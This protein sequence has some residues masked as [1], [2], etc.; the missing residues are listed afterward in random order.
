M[1]TKNRFE[2]RLDNETAK[3]FDEKLEKALGAPVKVLVFNLAKLGP[4]NW[5]ITCR[6]RDKTKWVLNDPKHL[7]EERVTW[8][9]KITRKPEAAVPGK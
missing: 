4:G 6:V 9:V 8:R 7:L 5:E 1:V 3:T 2:G